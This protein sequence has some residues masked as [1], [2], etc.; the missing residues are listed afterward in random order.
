MSEENKAMARRLVEG[1][2]AGDMEGTVD[3]LFAPRAARRV[4]DL[5]VPL[6]HPRARGRRH[7]DQLQGR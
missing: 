1:I 7:D 2:N 4:K 5:S 3:E 6:P